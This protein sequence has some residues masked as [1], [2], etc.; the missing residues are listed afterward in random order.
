[1]NINDLN[2]EE[3]KLKEKCDEKIKNLRI[4]YAKQNVKYSVGQTIDNGVFRILID[5]ILYSTSRL[6]GEPCPVY[7]GVELTKK[8]KP[9][10]D[11]SRASI[12][13][14]DKIE[15]IEWKTTAKITKQLR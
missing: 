8:G 11:G 4:E 10:K 3:K 5:N 14:S 15:V 6:Y 9:R 2:N 13:Q 1:M 7:C 12:Y